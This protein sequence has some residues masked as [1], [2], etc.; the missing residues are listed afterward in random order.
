[1]A[2]IR[3]NAAADG[4]NTLIAA[5]AGQKIVVI[6]LVATGQTTAGVALLRS[7]AA[8]TIH[9]DLSLGTSG[10]ITVA[11]TERVPLFVCDAGAALVCNNS[12]GLDVRGMVTFLMVPA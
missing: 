12:A 4:D 6:S 7:G 5:V 2:S 1:M 9:C 8:G 3:I 10:G 11:G